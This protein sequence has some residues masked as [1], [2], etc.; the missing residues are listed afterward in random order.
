MT[1]NAQITKAVLMASAQVHFSTFLG[2]ISSLKGSLCFVSIPIAN[3]S[4]PIKL[5]ESEF[6]AHAANRLGPTV[7]HMKMVH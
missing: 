6:C 2:F 7:V 1:T 3:H 5:V 4:L